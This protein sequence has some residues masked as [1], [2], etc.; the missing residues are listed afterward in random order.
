MS[1]E[2]DRTDLP[3][4]REAVALGLLDRRQQNALLDEVEALE[5]GIADVLNAAM[6]DH[7]MSIVDG[8]QLLA[9]T[10]AAERIEVAHLRE[11]FVTMEQAA[12]QRE[13]ERDLA[14]A[15]L[16]DAATAICAAFDVLG[17][18]GIDQPITIVDAARSRMA[19]LAAARTSDK[20]AWDEAVQARIDGAENLM[21]LTHE[22][23]AD[24]AAA[25][26]VLD[27]AIV[28]EGP[29]DITLQVLDRAAW[30]A[31]QARAGKGQG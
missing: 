1:T 29:G 5:H 31:W 20:R 15:D 13:T 23:Q 16:D 25:K 19:D 2:G 17:L 6:G 18:A 30:L 24:L 10:L 22:L 28:I 11:A 9:D 12:N 14:L 7:N 26:A 8:V 3:A 4:L 21:L 27:S